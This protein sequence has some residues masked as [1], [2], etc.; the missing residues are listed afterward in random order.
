[1]GNDGGSIPKRREVVKSKKREERKESYELAKAKSRLCALTKDP[2]GTKIVV[3]RLGL[4]YKKEEVI[5]RMLE[6][7]M[8]KAFRH[9]RKLRD[10]KDVKAEVREEEDGTHTIVCPVSQIEYN[11]FNNFLAIWSCGCLISEEAAKELKI[12][13]SCIHCGTKIEKKTDIVPLNQT[14][15]QQHYYL[16]LLDEQEANTKSK[17]GEKPGEALLGKRK[18]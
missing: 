3:C 16:R 17:K 11:G 7:N 8:P 1:M 5:K 4:L 15:E 12:K 14:P 13:D 9:I 10:I 18:T 6:K 2:L